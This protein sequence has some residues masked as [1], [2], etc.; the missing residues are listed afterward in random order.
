MLLIVCAGTCG[1]EGLRGKDV[2]FV[3]GAEGGAGGLEVL[4]L[5]GCASGCSRCNSSITWAND[6][7]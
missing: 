7:P 2:L 5:L 1:E 3:L 6:L 4:G